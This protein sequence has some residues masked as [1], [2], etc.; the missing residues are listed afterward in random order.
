[1]D[2]IP[3]SENDKHVMLSKMWIQ[4]IDDLF[5]SIPEELQ[6]KRDLD[7]PKPLTEAELDRLFKVSGKDPSNILSFLGAGAYE[8]LI[9]SAI[10]GLISRGE[11]FTAYT[12]YQAEVSQGTLQ[13]I[14]EFQSLIS[15]LAGLEAANASMYDGATATAEA[16]L[17]A[18]HINEHNEIILIDSLHPNYVKVSQ[19]FFQGLDVNLHVMS[20]EEWSA[21]HN[22]N[23]D[24]KISG[25][26]MQQ[27][28]FFGAIED[29]TGLAEQVHSH[30]GLLI[31]VV[32]PISL[33]ILKTPGEWGA[34]IAVGE[35]QP[36]GIPLSFGGPYLGFF[37]CI[38]KY[39]RKMPGRIVGMT[40]DKKGRRGYVLTLQTREQHIRREKA[41]SNICSNQ[42]L[43]AL[44]ATIYL[45]LLGPKGLT[46]VAEES[47]KRAHYLSESLNKIDGLRVHDNKPFFNEFVL[48]LP[49]K[50]DIALE[51]G[52]NKGIVPGLPLSRFF[53]DRPNDLL[54]AVTEKKERDELERLVAF[55]KE[56]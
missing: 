12:P 52:I 13:S 36:L 10:D 44:R 46:Q 29:I 11:F 8:H 51:K 17:M 42:A 20:L 22:A 18:N 31:M 25:L 21:W 4:S 33:A 55:F 30:S 15:H 50:A 3:L 1:M 23:P 56:G 35:G 47:T 7:L 54:I 16:A 28:T 41:T 39:V 26:I 37:A 27:P 6:L 19:T 53:K 5:S 45:S 14:Y 9:P 24:K 32:N 38:K 40:S 2:F 43:C 48:T 34:D 49:Y